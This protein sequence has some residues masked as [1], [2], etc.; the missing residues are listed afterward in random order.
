MLKK[1]NLNISTKFFAGIKDKVVNGIRLTVEDGINL[2][3]SPDLISIGA[4]ADYARKKKCGNKAYYIYNQ[5]I[6]YTNICI[7]QCLFCAY[8]R[9]KNQPEAFL[10]SIEDIKQK[11]YE[12]ID[13]P[14]TELHI[15]GGLN[16]ELDFNYYLTM[17]KTIK[18]IRPNAVIKAFTAVEIDYL[19]RISGLSIQ[20]VIKKLKQAGLDMMPGGGAEVLSDTIRKKLFPKKISGSKWLQVIKAVHKE[21]IKTN[22]T[23]LYGHIE[24]IEERIS[25][26][27][28]L[29][30]LQDETNGFIAFIP[31]AFHSQNTKLSRLP[32]TTAVDDLKTIAIS[33]LMLDNFNHI[34][35][36]W[37]MIG[38]KLAQTALFFGA[39]DLD[40]TII[41]EK[42]THFA[43]A[44]TAKGLTEEYIKNL[45]VKAGLTPV[46]R[47]SFY[48]PV[49]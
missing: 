5:H 44:K 33:R 19:A 31:L 13:E 46:C 38:A 22:A 23:M 24:T 8:S 1:N 48:N 43:G 29:R 21:K 32:A 2:Y 35:A 10:Y 47:D 26:L 27:I 25:H 15:V 41:E 30:E 42:I 37:V 18:L 4:L 6:N 20:Q 28:Q 7:N 9:K 40:G 14:I 17:L 45:I 16:P 34:K 3:K 49:A 12:R 39:D 36:Y 11:I